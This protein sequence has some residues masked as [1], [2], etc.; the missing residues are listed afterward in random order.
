MQEK[1]LDFCTYLRASLC[2]NGVV[3]RSKAVHSHKTGTC[4]DEGSRQLAPSTSSI[5]LAMINLMLE[6]LQK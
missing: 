5:H 4:V 6:R 3:V 2:I 1:A